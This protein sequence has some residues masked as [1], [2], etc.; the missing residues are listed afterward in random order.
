MLRTKAALLLCFLF[1]PLAQAQDP[2][3]GWQWQNPLPQG[4]SISAIRFSADKKRGWAVG[5]NGVVLTTNNGG[6]EWEEQQSP[7]NTTLYG[8][9]VKD[10]SRVVITGARGVVLTTNNGGGKWVLRPSGVR[11]H[12]FAVT[13]AL[14]RT[15][16]LR[17]TWH[18]VLP[19]DIRWMLEL[20]GPRVLAGLRSRHRQLEL[21]EATF[22]RGKDALAGALRGGNWLTR[23]ELRETLQQAGVDVSGVERL[24]HVIM[25][26]ELD[27]VICSGGLRGKQLTYA[28]FDERAPRARSLPRE[29]ALALLTRRYFTSHGPATLKDYVWWSGLTTAE[30]RAGIEAVKRDL[31]SEVAD[32]QRYWSGRDEPPAAAPSTS[33]YLLPNFDEFGVGYTDRSAHYSEEHTDA[34][35]LRGGL[36]LGNIVVVNG[37]IKG[38]WKRTLGKTVVIEARMFAELD[39]EEHGALVASAEC[40]GTFIG[41]PVDLR[42]STPAGLPVT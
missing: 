13:F 7:A 37:Q 39:R 20:T 14:L 41:L 15:H 1:V 32:G 35:N 18:F 33:A 28:L 30:A 19:E 27:M 4:N 23:Q 31:V 5:S 8:L 10:R 29:E 11:A 16:V 9:Y 38:E 34:V 6:F 22:A 25:R 26:A 3:R 17:P 2:Y 12:L 24:N 40:Y 42:V 36:A 21:D